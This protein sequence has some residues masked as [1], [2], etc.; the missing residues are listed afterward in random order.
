MNSLVAMAAQ[1]ALGE[2]QR[3]KGGG[4]E[5][6]EGGGVSSLGFLGTAKSVING[7]S[8]IIQPLMAT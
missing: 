7:C 6:G 2:R 4:G 5:E 3:V 8:K 1:P